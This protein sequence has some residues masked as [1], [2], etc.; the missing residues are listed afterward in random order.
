MVRWSARPRRSSSLSLL[1]AGPPRVEHRRGHRRRD[2]K[3]SSGEA[4][5]VIFGSQLP[6]DRRQ[7]LLEVPPVLAGVPHA[8][9]GYALELGP[10]VHARPAGADRGETGRHSVFEAEDA[11]FAD[12]PDFALTG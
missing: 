3:P 1:I 6:L 2:R 8:H 4:R 9:A 7:E 5:L 12:R 11:R 10:G